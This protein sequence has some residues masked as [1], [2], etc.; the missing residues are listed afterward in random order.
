MKEFLE[1]ADKAKL[2]SNSIITKKEKSKQDFLSYT[3]R[4]FQNN[5]IKNN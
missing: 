5:N 2:Q 3:Q 4:F 1:E